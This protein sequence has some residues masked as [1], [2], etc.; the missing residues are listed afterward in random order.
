MWYLSTVLLTQDLS[1]LV[2]VTTHYNKWNNL[3]I[4]HLHQSSLSPLSAPQLPQLP[5]APRDFTCP[6]RS[7]ITRS[8]SEQTRDQIK[9]GDCVTEK[10]E[11]RSEKREVRRL[12][13]LLISPPCWAGQTQV[14]SWE[15]WVGTLDNF[16]PS[17]AQSDFI[18]FYLLNLNL[19]LKC[20]K[21][22]FPLPVS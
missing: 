7:I 12:S 22:S 16:S 14:K 19:R 21:P 17:R 10:R 1:V 13:P 5:I 18:L 6:D 4:L 15:R 8:E 3:I 20:M 9:V 2:R 11:V